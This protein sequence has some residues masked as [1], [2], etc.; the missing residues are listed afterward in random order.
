MKRTQQIWM[1]T[2]EKEI[3]IHF[4]SPHQWK[5]D[6]E[7]WNV[8]VAI[9]EIHTQWI[10]FYKKYSARSLKLLDVIVFRKQRGKTKIIRLTL[11]NNL[12]RWFVNAFHIYEEVKRIEKE[13]F[14]FYAIVENA[15][16]LWIAILQSVWILTV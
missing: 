1:K 8:T 16:N 7:N 12:Q 13:I 15:R 10:L 4:N 9:G 2:P 6:V 5:M 3:K 11:P 14:T